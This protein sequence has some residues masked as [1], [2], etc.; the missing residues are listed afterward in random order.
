MNVSVARGKIGRCGFLASTAGR[1]AL[2]AAML[3]ALAPCVTASAAP[4]VQATA[5]KILLHTF[6]GELAANKRGLKHGV[7]AA[8]YQLAPCRSAV[9]GHSVPQGAAHALKVE[10][11]VQGADIALHPSLKLWIAQD[12]RTEQQPIGPKLRA[13][14]QIEVSQSTL[15]RSARWSTSTSQPGSHRRRTG[16]L[17]IRDPRKHPSCGAAR[18][19]WSINAAAGERRAECR[20]E[21]KKRHK[22][23]RRSDISLGER[24]LSP[25][26]LCAAEG[27][28]WERGLSGLRGRSK[29]R[30]WRPP[31]ARTEGTAESRNLT[32]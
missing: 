29:W 22:Q 10:L 9:R 3:F 30:A 23:T 16:H 6:K 20:I 18:C 31:P 7:A 12:S 26:I 28:D 24:L 32:D 5:Y 11:E 15:T 17:P 8:E 21:R 25:A 27:R 14:L 1:A 13:A 2:P 4:P 19:R